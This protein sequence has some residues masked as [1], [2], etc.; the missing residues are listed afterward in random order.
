MLAVV[1]W[2]RSMENK[3][4]LALLITAAADISFM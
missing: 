4:L 1:L 2:K 3:R